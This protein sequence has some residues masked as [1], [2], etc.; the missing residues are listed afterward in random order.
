MATSKSFAVAGTSK[1]NGRVK[2]R[3]AND[4]TRVKILVKTDH[5]DIDLID[6]PREMTKPEIAQ[7]LHDIDFAQGRPEV[8]EAIADL[9]KKN[10]VVLATTA[11]ATEANT[12][13]AE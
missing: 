1:L 9:A 2:V 5:T 7:Y 12:V 6:L 4:M 13:T 10:K 3:F 11:T 8:A